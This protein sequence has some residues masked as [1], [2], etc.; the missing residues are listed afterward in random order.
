MAHKESIQNGELQLSFPNAKHIWTV[1]SNVGYG[2]RNKPEDVRLVQFF[3][4]AS[5]DIWGKDWTNKP[6]KLVTDGI[7]GGNTW[8]A[9]RNFQ[10]FSLGCVVDGMVSAVNGVKLYSPKQHKLFTMY[11]LNFNYFTAREE[12]FSDLR[13]DPSLP[14]ELRSCLSSPMPDLV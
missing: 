2:Y 5:R 13:T 10:E 7:F 14:S 9:I 3:I 6:K 8:A 12:H 4:N 11:V 1:S